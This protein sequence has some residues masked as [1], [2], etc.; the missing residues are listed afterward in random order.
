MKYPNYV[1][2]VDGHIGTFQRIDQNE[3]PVYRFPQGERIADKW[4]LANGRSDSYFPTNIVYSLH[5]DGICEAYC[6]NGDMDLAKILAYSK[7]L[8]PFSELRWQGARIEYADAVY[9]AEQEK[10][11]EMN[12]DFDRGT[13]EIGFG[14][15]ADESAR[16][17]SGSLDN[18]P[19]IFD[20]L[21]ETFCDVPEVI[22]P[23]IIDGEEGMWRIADASVING[24]FYRELW[25]ENYGRDSVPHIFINEAEKVREEHR[26][27]FETDRTLDLQKSAYLF[28][29]FLLT[30]TTLILPESI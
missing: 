15:K 25:S 12:F 21:Y 4:E 1:R 29:Q 18:I 2:T 10:A 19:Q 8:D 28:R 24:T 6:A 22:E 3:M 20:S 30:M 26:I 11:I 14:K 16:I 7:K 27:L 9:L 5:K 13:V 23:K 17:V